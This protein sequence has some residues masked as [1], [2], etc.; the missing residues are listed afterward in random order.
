MLPWTKAGWGWVGGGEEGAC[1]CLYARM[2]AQLKQGK[3][4]QMEA[5]IKEGVALQ[6]SQL[7]TAVG[8]LL[9]VY[10]GHFVSWLNWLHF[11]MMF[12][13]NLKIQFYFLPHKL[14]YYHS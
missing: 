10:V 12:F 7:L 13:D 3:I 2:H 8:V 6:E 14:F 9:T 11:I 5:M 4:N 1:D